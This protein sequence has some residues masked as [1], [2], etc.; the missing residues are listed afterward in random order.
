MSFGALV[1]AGPTHNPSVEGSSPS[2]PMSK[3]VLGQVQGPARGESTPARQGIDHRSMSG[4]TPPYRR[5]KHRSGGRQHPA[6]VGRF[7]PLTGALA[8]LVLRVGRGGGGWRS[9]GGERLTV[10]DLHLVIGGQ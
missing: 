7:A 1:A 2:R 6:G 5:L 4:S 3:P 9:G 10:P 8:V